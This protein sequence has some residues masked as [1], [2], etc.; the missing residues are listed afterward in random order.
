MSLALTFTIPPLRSIKT[1]AISDPAQYDVEINT[2]R[3]FKSPTHTPKK[4]KKTNHTIR[5][6]NGVTYDPDQYD[7]EENSKR[8]GVKSN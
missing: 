2:A 1:R 3:G 5:V 6:E 8:H 4:S 7:V